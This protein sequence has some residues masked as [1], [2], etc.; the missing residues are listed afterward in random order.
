ME[1]ELKKRKRT[2]K[3]NARKKKIDRI[4]FSRNLKLGAL[5]IGNRVLFVSRYGSSFDNRRVFVIEKIGSNEKEYTYQT[6]YYVYENG[7]LVDPHMDVAKKYIEEEYHSYFKIV[8]D[9]KEQSNNFVFVTDLR[10]ISNEK[11][12]KESELKESTR[13]NDI[14]YSQGRML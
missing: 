1:K 11:G 3:E 8:N 10:K 6:F 9:H 5:R 7:A 13:H 2:A 4:E 12:E 14:F